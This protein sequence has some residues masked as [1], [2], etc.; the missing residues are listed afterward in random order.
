MKTFGSCQGALVY[1]DTASSKTPCTKNGHYGGLHL[2]KVLGTNN[3]DE[4]D[5]DEDQVQ[6]RKGTKTHS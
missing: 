1:Q 2:A 4:R 5:N 6:S 3:A